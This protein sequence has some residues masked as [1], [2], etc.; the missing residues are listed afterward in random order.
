MYHVTQMESKDF[1][2]KELHA[3]FEVRAI[4]NQSRVYH[5]YS[6]MDKML[7]REVKLNH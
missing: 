6:I 3:Y 4:N 1:M 2:T 5:P 7:K